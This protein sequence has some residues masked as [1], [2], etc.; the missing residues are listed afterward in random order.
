MTDT[1]MHRWVHTD[2]AKHVHGESN[3]RERGDGVDFAVYFSATTR[4]YIVSVYWI[5]KGRTDWYSARTRAGA[6][7]V[8][9][10]GWTPGYGPG[11]YTSLTRPAASREAR[12]TSAR[13]TARAAQAEQAR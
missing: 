6:M 10:P 3:G 9:A 11:S 1:T 4:R 8:G 13:A 12:Q 5:S 7:S 2:D